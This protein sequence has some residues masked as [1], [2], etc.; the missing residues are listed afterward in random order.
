MLEVHSIC[1]HQHILSSE[2][3]N[4]GLQELN[5]VIKVIRGLLGSLVGNVFNAMNVDYSSNEGVE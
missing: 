3:A 1:A 2:E 5:N 4:T